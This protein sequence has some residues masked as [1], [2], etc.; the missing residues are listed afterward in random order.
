MKSL[1]FQGS[2]MLHL[3]PER[4]VRVVGQHWR[5]G[6]LTPVPFFCLLVVG[7]RWR[8]CKLESCVYFF[9]MSH[10]LQDQCA[11]VQTHCFMCHLMQGLWH[12]WFCTSACLRCLGGIVFED[13]VCLTNCPVISTFFCVGYRTGYIY[14]ATIPH[15]C[16]GSLRMLASTHFAWVTDQTGTKASSD[17]F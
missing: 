17:L 6:I 13:D 12:A 7:Q 1:V 5:R 15:A 4:I 10:F 3:A 14:N 2:R 11:N 8:R 16:D 9:L